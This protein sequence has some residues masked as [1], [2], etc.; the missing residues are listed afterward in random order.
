LLLNLTELIEEISDTKPGSES[1][2]TDNHYVSSIVKDSLRYNA[3]I[4]WSWSW[5]IRNGDLPCLRVVR[6]ALHER[7]AKG[8]DARR[9]AREKSGGG[10]G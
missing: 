2:C 8:P 5:L 9:R 4:L 1:V 3:S 10:S 7:R 6:K